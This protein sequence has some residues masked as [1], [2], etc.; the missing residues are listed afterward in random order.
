MKVMVIV[1]ASKDCEAGRMPGKQRQEEMVKYNQEL[2]D[3]GVLLTVEGLQP[4][5]KGVRVRFAGQE[6]TVT[7]GP[8]S[9]TKELVG[10]FWLWN[11]KSMAE[12]IEWIKRC[13]NP[14]EGSGEFEI[15]PV[16]DPKDFSLM[17]KNP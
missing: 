3:A 14:H 11:V 7:D 10:G 4:S 13:P 5:S 12:A 9:E 16:H 6:R 15:R 2:A 1:K 8:F 17:P